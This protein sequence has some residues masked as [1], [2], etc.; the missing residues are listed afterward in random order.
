MKAEIIT[1]KL[2]CT[3]KFGF[4]IPDD[5]DYYG[6][7]FYVHKTDYNGAENGDIV[8]GTE[9]MNPKGKKPEAKITRIIKWIHA[10]K[11]APAKEV[12]EWVYSAGA[13]DFGFVDIPGQEKGFF[14]YGNKKSGA[15]D[16]DRVRANI[17]DYRGKK[18]AIV[19]EILDN[20][21]ALI[22]WTYKDNDRFGFV[23]P[24][25]GSDDIFI[26]GHRKLWARDGEKVKVVIVESQGKNREGIIREV[27]PKK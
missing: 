26:A 20:D 24:D 13:G 4:L 2:Q 5:R 9:I 16:G 15:K 12:V 7:D 17:V 6:G 8:E 19:V 27:H 25:D 1:G 10:E 3:E 18:E 22:E 23:L 11:K 21:E 14:C